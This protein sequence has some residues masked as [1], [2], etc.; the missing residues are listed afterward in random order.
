MIVKRRA[1]KKVF[2][3]EKNWNFSSSFLLIMEHFILFISVVFLCA[4][5]KNKSSVFTLCV[6]FSSTLFHYIWNFVIKVFLTRKK[7]MFF[8]MR[9]VV[10]LDVEIDLSLYDYTAWYFI[11]ITYMM[12]DPQSKNFCEILKK[13]FL[14][15][16]I[17]MYNKRNTI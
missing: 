2:T 5:F 13:I 14:W 11:C 7:N 12:G 17:Q 8:F 3:T 4:F 15:K 16:F 9:L 10:N 6:I 1:E